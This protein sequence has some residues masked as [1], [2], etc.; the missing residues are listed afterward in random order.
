MLRAEKQ[1]KGE[2]LRIK[3]FRDAISANELTKASNIAKIILNPINEYPKSL[4][5]YVSNITR[6]KGILCDDDFEAIKSGN[7][8]YR[9][10]YK[11]HPHAHL[12]EEKYELPIIPSET[13]EDKFYKYSKKNTFPSAIKLIAFYL[14][15]FHPFKENDQWWGKG[16]TEWTNVGKAK[17]LFDDHYQPHCPIHLGYYDLRIIE[18]MIAQAE[19]AKNYGINGFAYYVYWFNGKTIMETPLNN[20]LKEPKVDIP[21]CITWANENWTRRWDGKEEDIL[22]SQE[23]SLADSKEFLKYMQKYFT[24]NRY[25]C[26][27]NKPVVIIYRADIIPEISLIIEQWREMAVEMGFA[28]LY[29]IA[30]Q[31]FGIKDPTDLGFDAAVEFPP[32]DVESKEVR[33]I[34][35]GINSK[36]TGCIYDYREVVSKKLN[37]TP[38]AYNQHYTCMLAWDNV[39]RKEK[40]GNIF[41]MFSLGSYQNW[42]HNNLSKTIEVATCKTN[43]PLITFVNAWNEWAEGTHLEPDQAYGYGYLE[44]THAILSKFNGPT[45]FYKLLTQQLDPRQGNRKQRRICIAIHCYYL[46][47]FEMIFRTISLHI[48]MSEVDLYITT[49]TVEKAM[50]IKA[51][52]DDSIITII[53]NQGRD[54]LPFINFLRSLKV[55]G[56]EYKISLKL[57]TKKSV[58]RTDG[59][60]LLEENLNTLVSNTAMKIIEQ[61]FQENPKLGLIVSE[62]CFIKHKTNDNKRMLFNEILIKQLCD[63]IGIRFKQSKFPVGSMFWYRQSALT[64]LIHID[65]SSFY[66]EIGLPDGTAAHAIERIF[67][68]LVKFEGYEILEI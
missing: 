26:H 53:P 31:T 16:F 5:S 60:I 39:A 17:P 57:H 45:S 37:D 50:Q 51:I 34:H 36:F 3:A 48:N 20:M 24:D 1:R 13:H 8:I 65:S 22:I 35:T 19:L 40:Q 25:I 38:P 27:E 23:H 33:E 21:F 67:S 68:E 6:S 29:L 12:L 58:Y 9:K 41:S 59:H 63:K 61:N 15:Q 64:R 2:I 30:A 10:E 56:I 7:Y 54:V 55:A 52:T 11:Y 18:N 28:G 62:A 4:K 32:H 44:A 43:Y 42:L 47:A 46:D 49:D 66:P 14:P